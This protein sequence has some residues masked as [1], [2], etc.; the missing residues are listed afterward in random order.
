MACAIN[1]VI[2]NNTRDGGGKEEA[3]EQKKMM[4]NCKLLCVY[5]T[6]SGEARERTCR[7]SLSPQQQQQ[8]TSKQI[9]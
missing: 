8:T 6:A 7:S 9:S 2:V 3:S 1:I 5:L 4:K